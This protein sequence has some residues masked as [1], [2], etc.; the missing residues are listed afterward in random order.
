MARSTTKTVASYLRELPADRRNHEKPSGWK[1]RVF[2]FRGQSFVF[3]R[4]GL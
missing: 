2:A 3:S 1:F 4:L